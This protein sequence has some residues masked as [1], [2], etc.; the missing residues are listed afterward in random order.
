MGAYAQKNE[1][2]RLDKDTLLNRVATVATTEGDTV[3]IE[4]L[5]APDLKIFARSYKKQFCI[6]SFAE[7]RRNLDHL[8]TR[9]KDWLKRKPEYESPDIDFEKYTL[10]GLKDDMRIQLEAECRLYHLKKYG[11][12]SFC[13]KI[14][15]A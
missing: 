4:L 10:I 3:E 12:I 5:D 1:A 14:C 9:G 7:Y 15:R 6:N 8:D 13:S 2:L 11:R